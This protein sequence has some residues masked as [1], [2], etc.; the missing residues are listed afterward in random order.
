MKAKNKGEYEIPPRTNTLR[1]ILTDVT[2]GPK[3]PHQ[4]L[5]RKQNLIKTYQERAMLTFLAGNLFWEI[6]FL[7]FF[8]LFLD[9]TTLT[10]IMTYNTRE[11][12]MMTN[13]ARIPYIEVIKNNIDCGPSRISVAKKNPTCKTP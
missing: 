1:P 12:T 9:I 11:L 6:E 2:S 8:I 5:K 4:P 10:A 3:H 7:C 13:R